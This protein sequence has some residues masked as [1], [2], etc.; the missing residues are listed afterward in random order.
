MS[1]ADLGAA[2]A[3]ATLTAPPG[4]PAAIRQEGPASDATSFTGQ[5]APDVDATMARAR[6]AQAE[7]EFWPQERID[8]LVAAAGW[9]AYQEDTARSLAELAYRETGLGDPEHLFTLYRRRVL[10]TLRDLHGVVTTGIIEDLPERG[11]RKLAKPIGVIAVASPATAPCSGVV[12]N[13]L[14][15]LKTRNAVVITPNPRARHS[16]AR[17]VDLL[18]QSLASVGAPPD[19]VQCLPVTDR[20]TTEALMAA[21]DLVIAAGG[22]GTVRR[23]Y[24]SGTPAISAGVGN[25]AVIVDASAD[26]AAAAELIVLGGSFNNGTSCS[27]ESNVLVDAGIAAAFRDQ[28][29]RQGAHLCDPAETAR[30]RTLL[31]P[32]GRQLNRDA[33]GRPATALAAAAG[34]DLA[35]PTKTTALVAQLPPLTPGGVPALDDPMLGEKLAPV[36]TVTTF[37]DFDDALVAVETLLARIGQGHSC[38]IHTERPDRVVRLAERARAGRVMVNQSTA[39]GNSGSFDNGM[40]FTQVIASGSWGGCSRSENVTWRDFLNYT[41]VS[42]P[43]P[44]SLPDEETLFGAHWRRLP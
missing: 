1:S 33:V 3:A 35:E 15:M 12:G 8:D 36:F 27:S 28:L 41:Y 21:A 18:R 43:L 19:L 25:P 23:A 11:L 9:A 6:R 2:D 32:D 14:P 13:A 40:A 16:A 26:V 30:L 22:P 20:Q 29:A 37:T 38:G 39:V 7:V 31:W 42:H 24:R 34:I 4:G 44:P 17:T 10:G 5:A